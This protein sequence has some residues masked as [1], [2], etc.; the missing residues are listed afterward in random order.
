MVHSKND[1]PDNILY[2]QL[3]DNT[4]K[5]EGIW[6]EAKLSDIPEKAREWLDKIL[7]DRKYMT[8]EI[9]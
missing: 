4:I 3:K 5:K 2:N 6:K 8:S 1:S 9:S 7:I